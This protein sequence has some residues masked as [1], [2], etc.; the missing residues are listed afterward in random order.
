MT[1][2]PSPYLY[3]MVRTLSIESL[4]GEYASLPLLD[5]RAPAEYLH[6]HI[7][8]ALSLPLF[9]NEERAVVGTTY[10]QQGRDAAVLA[11]FDI[12]GPKWAELIRQ[13][14]LYAPSKKV[15]VHCWRGGM[16]SGAVA[17]ALS[18]YGFEVYQ[19]QGGYK[20]FRNWALSQFDT[21]YRLQLIGGMTGSGKTAVLH[22]LKAAK[23][24]VI[25]LEDLARHRGSSYGSMNSL[26]QPSQEQFENNL[27]TQLSLLN[28]NDRIWMEDESSMIGK[29][30][31]PRPLWKQMRQAHL[32]NLMLPFEQR[33]ER[34]VEEYGCLDKDF[35]VACT[36]RIGKRLGPEQTKNAI[37]AIRGNRMSE[38]V[39]WV[40]RYYDKT[41]QTGLNNRPAGSVLPLPIHGS[42]PVLHA[43]QLI[44]L[45]KEDAYQQH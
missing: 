16:R 39:E 19:L 36:E 31:I 24:Q 15:V 26:V 38:F 14:L 43:E 44:D 3:K 18:F 37:A 1:N 33:V 11:G 40:L 42:D 5:V 29:C 7:P 22:A 41:Y 23:Q 35:L 21:T 17:W 25:D 2:S 30:L 32:V 9:S 10:K 45:F 12:V 8:G 13:A 34:L 20:A 4:V 28:A 6:G 27:A